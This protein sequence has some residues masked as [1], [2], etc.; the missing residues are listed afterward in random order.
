MTLV[1]FILILGV[2]IFVHELGHYIFAKKA[3]I[4][5]HEFA[6]GMG[7]KIYSFKRKNDETLY[8]IRL[9][10]IGGM[11]QL[12]GEEIEVDEDIPSDKRLQ[13]KTWLERF[14]TIIAGCIFNFILALL[15]L[16]LIGLIY[17]A[18]EQK[19]YIGQVFD[20]YPAK[21]AGFEAGDLILKINGKSVKTAEDVLMKFYLDGNGQE[22]TFEIKKI[23]GKIETYKVTPKKE[24]VDKETEYKY[25]IAFTDKINHG[26]GTSIKFAF[27]KFG[28]IVK[29]MGQVVINLITGN[30]GINRLAGPIGIYNMVGEG[31]QAGFINIIYLIATLSIN[32]GFVN[33]LP[34]PAFDGGRVIFLIIEKI[35]GSKVNPKVENI[36]HAIGFVLLI[37]LMILVTIQDISKL[38]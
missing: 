26:L 16:F 35:K 17:G 20:D 8:S 14:L 37:I 11:T 33:L 2:I 7:P 25:G 19:P 15:F 1:Y 34:F 21:E 13:S 24:I 29:M 4:Y 32:V 23:S 3:G 12:A 27:T 6:L 10:P 28:S 5:V 36:I 30:M 18:P 22:L 9:I 31:A 38:G